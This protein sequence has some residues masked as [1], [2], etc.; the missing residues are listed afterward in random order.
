MARTS[1]SPRSPVGRSRERGF[2]LLLVLML[3][4]LAI[5]IVS[6]L[7]YQASLEYMAAAN[8]AD[9]S[10]IEYSIDGQ[11]ELALAHLKYDRRQN[12]IDSEFDDWN[13]S[14]Q[15]QR[16]D[17]DVVLSQRIVDESGKFD[18]MRLVTGNDQ[19]QARAR[20]ILIDILDSFRDG[21][22]TDKEK[23]GDIDVGTAEELADKIV[24]YI[25]RDGGQ[26]QVPKPKTTPPNTLLLLEEIGFADNQKLIPKLLV[27]IKVRD[28]V[29]AGLYRYL[30]VYGPGKVNLNTA[31]LIVL[32][33]EFPNVQDKDYGKGILDRRQAAP[34]ANAPAPTGSAAMNSSGSG[35]GSSSGTSNGGNPFS[36]VGT[37]VDG[38]VAGL[39]AEIL[40]RNGIDAAVEFDVKSDFFSIRIDG[41]TKRT[42]R[43]EL[44][45]VQ[46]VK[47]DGFRF[48][49]HQER[50]D[51][52]LETEED[53]VPGSTQ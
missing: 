34:D 47:T 37:L 8:I 41:S 16:T 30:T 21:I 17:E 19:Q 27:D 23:G 51:P 33:A 31:P 14:E 3:S 29:A 53:K 10:K 45:A 48:L 1:P 7:A 42:Q 46:R 5:V 22:A 36:D 39:T 52:I 2:A 25:K 6:E 9:I 40:Q 20:K 15:R 13:A 28:K 24:K 12:E 18:L 35:T 11:L 43:R 4:S 32:R 44:F 38:S 49:L 26:G 50:T